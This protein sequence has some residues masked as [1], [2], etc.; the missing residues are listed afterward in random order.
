[1]QEPKQALW[2]GRARSPVSLDP[3][4]EKRPWGEFVVIGRWPP[5]TVKVLKVRPHSRLSLQKHM[6]R[7]EEWLCL[8]GSGVAQLGEERHRLEAGSKVF[9]P[10]NRLHRLSSD[11]GVEILEVG[12]G[13]FKEEDIVRV[14]DDYGRAGKS[15]PSEGPSKRPA[16]RGRR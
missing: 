12:Y 6:H 15:G 1:M 16:R 10:R 4:S 13:D 9:V 7:D 8:S 5:I 2:T 11:S 3:Q 14:E